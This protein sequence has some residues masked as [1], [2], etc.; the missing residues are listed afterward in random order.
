MLWHSFPAVVAPIIRGAAPGRPLRFSPWLNENEK[1]LFQKLLTLLA[2]IDP[3]VD[4]CGSDK[5]A[6]YKVGSGS[7]LRG[8]SNKVHPYETSHAAWSALSHAVDLLHAVRSMV[9]DAAVIH[10]YAPYTLL[11]ATIENAAVAVW[12]LAPTGRAER[13]ERRFRHA[14][15]DI[16]G[17]GEEVK[18]LIG[19]P[20]PRSKQQRIDEIRAIAAKV[21]GVNVDRA[22]A[23]ASFRKVVEVA[24][25]QVEFGG[26]TTRILWHMGSGIAHGALWATVSATQVDELPGS[27]AGVKDMR[28]SAGMEA[29]FLMTVAASQL[30][31]KGFELYKIRA[32]PI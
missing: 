20:G 3:W 11:R 26:K 19:I 12:L 22:S 2:R 18:E 28:V 27:P 9:R 30:I 10:S 21:T 25:D 23:R 1:A 4:S 5:L 14:A 32:R 29:I 8:D 24:G 31:D 16:K 17:G 13:V 7:A 6:D 15:A